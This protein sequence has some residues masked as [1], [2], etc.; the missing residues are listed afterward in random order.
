M[1]VAEPSGHAIPGIERKRNS[2]GNQAV[3]A[4]LSW[5]KCSE[6]KAKEEYQSARMGAQ[7]TTERIPDSGAERKEKSKIR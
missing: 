1:L 2:D 5:S 6:H 3:R 7:A 4:G